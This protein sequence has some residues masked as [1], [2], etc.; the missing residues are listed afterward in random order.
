MNRICAVFDGIKQFNRSNSQIAPFNYEMFLSGPVADSKPE[1]CKL[2]DEMDGANISN[3]IDAQK[4]DYINEREA[5][6]GYDL[7]ASMITDEM[8]QRYGPLEV[9]YPYIVKHLFSKENLDKAAHKKM[10]WRVYGDIALQ[11]LKENL[12]SYRECDVCGVKYP[13]W[14]TS[15]TCTKPPK[16]FCDCEVCGKR[17]R[18]TGPKQKRCEDCQ[19]LYEIDSD[20]ERKKK[21]YQKKKEEKLQRS[22]SLVS[23]LKK[24]S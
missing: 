18:R 1:V 6:A 8:T 23:R 24:T 9:T 20:N 15:H 21:D 7:L 12:K 11:H 19:A 22:T 16:G 5:R 4:Y 14:K 13:M 17:F 10:F 2:F 3:I